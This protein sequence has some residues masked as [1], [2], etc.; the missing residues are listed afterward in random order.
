MGSAEPQSDRLSSEERRDALIDIA[1]ALLKEGGPDR[2]SMGTVAERAEVT[3]TLVYK[4]FANRDDLL[5]A[6][7]RREAARLDAQMAAEVLAAEGFEARLRTFVRV[8]LRAVDTH[9]WIFVPLQAQ[10]HERGFRS[11]QR[12]RDR[13]TVR[14]FAE[15]A[16]A[17]FDLPVRDAIAALSVL[18]SGIASLRTQAR[19]APGDRKFLEDLYVDLVVGALNGL[20]AR[21]RSGR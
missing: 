1:F 12:S 17:E 21:G 18:L 4:H 20:R 14:A 10:S 15:L 6:V 7:F 8:V 9:G 19:K 11:E 2:V 3:R 5:A 13:R 16:S